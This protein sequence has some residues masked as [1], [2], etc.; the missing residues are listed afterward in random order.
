MP[1]SISS[2][3]VSVQLVSTV[4]DAVDDVEGLHSKLDRKRR[5]EDTNQAVNV[6]FKQDFHNEVSSMKTE[7]EGF[8]TEQQQH[9]SNFSDR[10]GE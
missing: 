7:L 5:V 4:K 3:N 6:K 10:I 9:C 1:C 2:I 8:A